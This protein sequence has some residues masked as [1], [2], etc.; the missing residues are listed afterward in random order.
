MSSK[1]AAWDQIDRVQ[2]RC[3][4]V[5]GTAPQHLEAA[6]GKM[7]MLAPY[8]DKV[9][10]A[11]YIDKLLRTLPEEYDDPRLLTQVLDKLDECKAMRAISAGH[12]FAP[13]QT[14]K[15]VMSFTTGIGSNSDYSEELARHLLSSGA[16]SAGM[17]YKD[18]TIR[19]GTAYLADWAIRAVPGE[20]VY[21][22]LMPCIYGLFDTQDPLII[23]P[24]ASMAAH[25]D[26]P[27]LVPKLCATLDAALRGRAVLTSTTVS[28]VFEACALNKYYEYA[29]TITGQPLEIAERHGS[30]L[31]NAA[32]VVQHMVDVTPSLAHLIR[33]GQLNRHEWENIIGC[34]EGL[35]D[36]WMRELAKA[37]LQRK[38]RRDPFRWL[39]LQMTLRVIATAPLRYV[40]EIVD[41][42]VVLELVL[43]AVREGVELPPSVMNMLHRWVTVLEG[44]A[45]AVIDV[46]ADKDVHVQLV[47]A[48][49]NEHNAELSSAANNLLDLCDE[50]AEE[51][52]AADD[53]YG[54]NF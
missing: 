10:P 31:L 37:A 32:L 34:A 26:D 25:I 43:M 19:R 2:K 24:M 40:V 30:V 3:D 44:H 6:D 27:M 35:C 50:D 23:Q 45:D 52:P 48:Y 14:I 39:V 1:R 54:I 46:L 42:D 33:K 22:A 11:R 51:E 21:K 16:I 29:L 13:A 7:V 28:N 38:L 5:L 15:L 53:S 49:M 36:K 17:N 9:E 4:V 18:P 47:D 8:T 20:E 12:V 41:R